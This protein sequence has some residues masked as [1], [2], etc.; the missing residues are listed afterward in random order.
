MDAK[1]EAF[2]GE[3]S[4]FDEVIPDRNGG[5]RRGE[6]ERESGGDREGFRGEAEMVIEALGHGRGRRGILPI[7]LGNPEEGWGGRRTERPN[8]RTVVILKNVSLKAHT[9]VI[10]VYRVAGV[11]RSGAL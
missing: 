4:D 8:N 5:S 6:D 11:R 9:R 2:D 7:G 1:D 10:G 3:N